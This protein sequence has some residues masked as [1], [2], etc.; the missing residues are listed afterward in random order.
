MSKTPGRMTRPVLSILLLLGFVSAALA[1]SDTGV[2][3]GVVSDPAARMIVGA[4]VTLKNN[5]T[6]AS[7][8]YITDERGVYFF[9]FLQPGEYT[10]Q[11]KA[12]GF[13]QYQASDIH[14]QVAQVLRLDVDLTIGQ[15][16]EILEVSVGARS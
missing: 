5:A 8:D 13:K 2:L 6:G 12:N 3:F 1:Q 15:V 7:R 9:T 14:V 10:V 4:Q 16:K 11:F